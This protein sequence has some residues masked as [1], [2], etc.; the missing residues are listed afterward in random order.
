MNIIY[1]ITLI[2]LLCSNL[3][4][5]PSWWPWSWWQT[6]EQDESAQDLLEQEQ[7]AIDY[8]R[9]EDIQEGVSTPIDLIE[10]DEFTQT[11][12]RKEIDMIIIEEVLKPLLPI[13]KRITQDEMSP[14]IRKIL[15]LEDQQISDLNMGQY[16]N[17]SQQ[18]K[19]LTDVLL[20]L[21]LYKDYPQVR[22]YEI[23]RRD[24][25]GRF[26]DNVELAILQEYKKLLSKAQIQYNIPSDRLPNM[27]S[28]ALL[29]TSDRVGC[30]NKI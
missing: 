27:E 2:S 14:I 24:R 4:T 10:T 28:Y 22:A 25:K 7:S 9:D 17:M 20:K 26:L 29:Y 8:Q 15:W 11:L 1:R 21:D 23:I 12:D 5:L 13:V 3:V 16:L 6:S 19:K 30:V 18:L